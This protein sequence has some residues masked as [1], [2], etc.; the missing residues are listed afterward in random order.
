[1]NDKEFEIVKAVA[2]KLEHKYYMQNFLYEAGDL[3]AAGWAGVE[4]AHKKLGDVVNDSTLKN[5]VRRRMADC[6]RRLRNR[7]ANQT[8]TTIAFT[9]LSEK[10][11]IAQALSM[12]PAPNNE[13]FEDLIKDLQPSERDIVRMY[14]ESD[15]T[16][17]EIGKVVGKTE[18]RICQILKKKIYPRIL[19][20]L[21]RI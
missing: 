3:Y 18:S 12:P 16:H 10:V 7:R 4:E 19:Q 1:M 13:A 11:D 20:G 2:K 5:I 8:N 9:D 6:F 14:F 15:M 17:G 21:T